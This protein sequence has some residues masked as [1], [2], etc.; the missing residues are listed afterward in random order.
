MRPLSKDQIHF[1]KREGYLIVRG[2]L[3]DDLMHRAREAMWAAAPGQVDRN[4]PD[5][6]IGPLRGSTEKPNQMGDYTWKFR[7]PG[8]ED[9]MIRLV[10]TD[11]RIW[12]MAEQLLG[13]GSLRRPERVRG[14]YSTFPEGDKPPATPTCHCDG[15]PF[16]LGVVGYIDRVLPDG[17]GLKVWP[18]SHQRFYYDF[19]GRY[20]YDKKETYDRTKALFD[21]QPYVDFHGEAGDMIFW[22]HRLGHAGGYNRSRQIRKAVFHDYVKEDLDEMIDLPPG[23]DM[24]EDWSEEVRNCD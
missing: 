3:D 16:H 24:W 21:Q 15:H 17:G 22:H 8:G 5:S 2:I 9:W 7:E 1:F 10:A 20:S 18:G 23:E 19:S 4:D 6:W 14:I 12:S 13:A 11:P